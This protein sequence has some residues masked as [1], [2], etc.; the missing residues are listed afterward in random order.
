MIQLA[1]LFV[2]LGVLIKYGKFYHLIVGYSYMPQN[3][4]ER[5]DFN[6]IATVYR[7]VMF[8]M[9][10]MVIIGWGLAIVTGMSQMGYNVFVLS[11]LVGIPFLI[12]ETFSKKYRIKH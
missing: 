5:Y 1:L 10:A 7:N 4:I 8:G 3:Q 6:R 9:A 2:V 12:I 11:L